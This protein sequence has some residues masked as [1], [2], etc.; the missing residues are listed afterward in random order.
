MHY[1]A[2]WCPLLLPQLLTTL[3]V[4]CLA[5]LC[6]RCTSYYSYSVYRDRRPQRLHVIL[7]HLAI[8]FWLF[9][10]GP[11]TNSV[12]Y[13]SFCT[14][15]RRSLISLQSLSDKHRLSSQPFVNFNIAHQWWKLISTMMVTQLTPESMRLNSFSL[16]L[17]QKFDGEE[18]SQ[19]VNVR[20]DATN[21]WQQQLPHQADLS[22]FL[23][24]QLPCSHD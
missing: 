8:P 18:C 2:C 17:L 15:V 1:R 12:S 5:L 6:V 19:Q 14:H 11:S 20:S 23:S 21:S 10:C 9:L 24:G 13:Y 22:A 4:L 7:R 16:I 3:A